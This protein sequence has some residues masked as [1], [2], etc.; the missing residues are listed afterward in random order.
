MVRPSHLAATMLAEELTS[1][2]A[3][4][5]APDQPDVTPSP[6]DSIRPEDAQPAAPELPELDDD[7]FGEAPET[8]GKASDADDIGL[9]EYVF[10]DDFE[11]FDD[12]SLVDRVRSKLSP[13]IAII[14]AVAVIVVLAGIWMG[15]RFLSSEPEI[16]ES[17]AVTAVLV[18]A[19]RLSK[20]NKVDE[21]IHLLREFPAT[22][23]F[24][25]RIDMKIARYEKML[26]PTEPTPV[27]ETAVRAEEFLEQGL[28]WAA[29]TSAGEGLKKHPEDQG[30]IEI[31]NQVLEIEPE[32]QNLDNALKYRDHR[33]AVSI[34]D[35]LLS[36][37]P[38]QGDLVVVL[39]RSLFNA[40]LAEARTYNLTG[41]EKHLERLLDMKP[42]D[43]EAI[44][45]LQFVKKYKVRGADIQL[46]IFIRSLSER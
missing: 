38:E 41:A 15:S 45:F 10:D 31:Q 9:D 42:T 32:A 13:R 8:V 27:P 19:E 28:W 26:A 33:A 25:Q 17:A 3:A 35:E 4:P 12:Q 40:A 7:L 18:E 14:A 44:R 6:P 39:E 20:E 21:A 11:D 22:G 30:L 29:Y 16:D 1:S 37:Y 23:L 46:E 36:Q 24:K 2:P 5:T 43:D 34:T